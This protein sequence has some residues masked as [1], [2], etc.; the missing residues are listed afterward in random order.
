VSALE[1]EGA[2]REAELAARGAEASSLA[3]AH[4]AAAAQCDQYIMDL[5]VRC[6]AVVTE[7]DQ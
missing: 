5:Q 6:G 3:D 4:R 1:R 7:C 2:A